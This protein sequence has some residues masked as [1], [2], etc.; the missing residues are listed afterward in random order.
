[1]QS[2]LAGRGEAE[3]TLLRHFVRAKGDKSNVELARA[4]GLTEGMVRA[5]CS[6]SSRFGIDSLSAIVCW[7]PDFEPLVLEV[8][9]ARGR[10]LD[11]TN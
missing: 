5:I 10:T 9:R 11:R 6:G 7:R 1:V 2:I 4:L 8:L 3:R